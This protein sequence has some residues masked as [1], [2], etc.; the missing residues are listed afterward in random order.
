MLYFT[1]K[2]NTQA[3]RSGH[4]GADSK[5][6]RFCLWHLLKPLVF[7]GFV[8]FELAFC[9]ITFSQFSRTLDFSVF[10]FSADFLAVF[11]ALFSQISKIC[12]IFMGIFLIF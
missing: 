4:N 8:G 5:N 10:G 12:P 11:L 7:I 6:Y 1:S 2:L 3:Y 9:E